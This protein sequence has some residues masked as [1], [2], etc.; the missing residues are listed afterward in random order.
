VGEHEAGMMSLAT[1]RVAP[2]KAVLRPALLSLPVAGVLPEKDMAIA[3][4]DQ[5]RDPRWQKKRL[6]ALEASGWECSN[7]GDETKMLHVHHK[8]YVKGRMAWEYDLEELAVLCEPCHE[9]E[10][11]DRALLDRVI[12]EASPGM[13]E[14]IIGLAA[15]YLD[16]GV[17][18]HDLGLGEM[19]RQT[20]PMFYELGVAASV[21]ESQGMTEWRALIRRHAEQKIVSPPVRFL[22][23]VWDEK[24]KKQ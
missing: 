23:E 14:V 20:T 6:E 12:A 24:E 17:D 8:R 18:L 7:C 22:I 21:L 9:Q 16:S 15:G 1:A 3:Y 11:E 19:C 4:R 13:L 2:E 10:H 5:L